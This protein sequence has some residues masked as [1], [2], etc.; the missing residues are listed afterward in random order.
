MSLVSNKIN[1]SK[2]IRELADS[3]I[4]LPWIWK[5]KAQMILP[6]QLAISLIVFRDKSFKRLHSWII[7]F[8]FTF[9]T[10]DNEQKNQILTSCKLQYIEQLSRNDWFYQIKAI[11]VDYIFFYHCHACNDHAF[12]RIGKLV[13]FSCFLIWFNPLHRAYDMHCEQ[14]LVIITPIIMRNLVK[15]KDWTIR[16]LYTFPFVDCVKSIRNTYDDEYLFS[17]FTSTYG[18]V[19]A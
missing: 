4:L 13:A 5:S 12:N 8:N 9:T 15:K 11:Y 3:N 18:T 6:S 16:F 19:A 10:K 14:K 1:I 17:C 7:M 2:T